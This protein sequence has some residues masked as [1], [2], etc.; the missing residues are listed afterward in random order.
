M[1]QKERQK[2]KKKCDALWSKV[3]KMFWIKKYGDPICPWCHD[4][5]IQHSDHIANRWKHSTRWRIE[6]CVCL[7]APCHLFRKKREPAEWCDMVIDTIGIETYRDIIKESKKI[8]KDI[9][10]EEVF[11]YLQNAEREAG[12]S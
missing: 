5:Y 2:L 6:N 11:R 1:N 4:R 12:E 8:A 3:T 9:D 10:Y 7:C